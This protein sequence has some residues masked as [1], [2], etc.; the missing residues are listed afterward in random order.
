[1]L[2][3]SKHTIDPA[4]ISQVVE[5]KPIGYKKEWSSLKDDHS[6]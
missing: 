2:K 4:K 3:E 6:K 1:M 5:L